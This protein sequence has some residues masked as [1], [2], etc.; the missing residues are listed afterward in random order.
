MR[1]TRNKKGKRKR[2]REREAQDDVESLRHPWSRRADAGRGSG[3]GN[4]LHGCREG[5]RARVDTGGC[6]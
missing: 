5:E 2:E 6:G 4:N 3:D 1:A